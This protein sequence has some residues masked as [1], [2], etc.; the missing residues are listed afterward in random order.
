[1][2]EPLET[3][4]LLA[5]TIV[6]PGPDAP[7]DLTQFAAFEY[8]TATT[9][10]ARSGYTFDRRNAQYVQTATI[11]NN[12]PTAISG[13]VS[14]VLHDLRVASDDLVNRTGTVPGGQ[15]TLSGQV[16]E[17]PY[18]DF[19]P[20]GGTLAPQ[21][22][23]TVTL[24]ISDPDNAPIFYIPIVRGAANTSP[25]GLE[26]FFN[27]IRLDRAPDGTVAFP[28]VTAG[29]R[30][31]V[32][33]KNFSTSSRPLDDVELV[34]QTPSGYFFDPKSNNYRFRVDDSVQGETHYTFLDT[35]QDQFKTLGANESVDFFMRGTA[36]GSR[37]G[38]GRATRSGVRMRFG[39]VLR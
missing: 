27:R 29:V 31:T 33:M 18:I 36:T 25:S 32:S 16:F 6:G 15:S 3:R 17:D 5:A 19:T 1:V 24:R 4:N 28:P 11:K 35:T 30:Q 23:A 26:F 8:Y 13:P 22:T 39:S 37:G 10:V 14:L 7:V 2:L 20:P 38:T 9:D 34:S 21:A 12:G